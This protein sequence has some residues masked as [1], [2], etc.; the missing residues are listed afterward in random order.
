MPP[1]TAVASNREDHQ[2]CG[3][4]ENAAMTSRRSNAFPVEKRAMEQARNTIGFSTQ[5]G[6]E[7][8][9]CL[10]QLALV[11]EELWIKN[12]RAG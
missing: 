10:I 11:R 8:L 6:V 2:I 12:I 5:P 1:G 4:V 7:C 3:I 9:L